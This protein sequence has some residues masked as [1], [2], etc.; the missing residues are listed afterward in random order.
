MI[1]FPP[2]QSHSILNSTGGEEAIDVVIGRGLDHDHI[3]YMIYQIY[4]QVLL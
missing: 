4:L 2:V 3:S 1:S